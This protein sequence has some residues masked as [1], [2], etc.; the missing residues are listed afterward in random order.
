[1]ADSYVFRRGADKN[2]DPMFM[3]IAAKDATELATYSASCCPGS[4]GYT[5]DGATYRLGT[6]GSWVLFVAAPTPPAAP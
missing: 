1:M 3:E 5:D 6:D 2:L 4:V